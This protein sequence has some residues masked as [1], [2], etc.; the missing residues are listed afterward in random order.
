MNGIKDISLANAVIS[1][2]AVYLRRKLK[3][4]KLIV[5][6]VGKSKFLQVH[7]GWF[8]VSKLEKDMNDNN[9][10]EWIYDKNITEMII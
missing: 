10:K 9:S 8:K 5:F 2:K 4:I 7:P 6:E 3:L 1:G